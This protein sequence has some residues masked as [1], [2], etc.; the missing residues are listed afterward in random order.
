MDD[1]GGEPEPEA[2]PGDGEAADDRPARLEA[3]FDTVGEGLEGGALTE[4]EKDVIR[5]LHGGCPDFAVPAFR[6][7]QVVHGPGAL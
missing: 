5:A 1:E 7:T 2:V 6:G 4:Q 3:A